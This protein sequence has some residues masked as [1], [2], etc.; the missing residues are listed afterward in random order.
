MFQLHELDE[1]RLHAMKILYYIKKEQK[2]GTIE[3]SKSA[4]NSTKEIKYYYFIKNINIQT[5]KIKIPL[6]WTV[7]GETPISIRICG[8][9]RERW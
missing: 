5:T 7:H 9:I 2:S 4:K 1:F 3:N 6:A 8:I